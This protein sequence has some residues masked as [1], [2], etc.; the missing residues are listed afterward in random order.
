MS[1]VWGYIKYVCYLCKVDWKNTVFFFSQK[2]S[3]LDLTWLILVVELFES[4]EMF[5]YVTAQVH[6]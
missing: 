2:L 3:Y 4:Q 5:L 1:F 6:C